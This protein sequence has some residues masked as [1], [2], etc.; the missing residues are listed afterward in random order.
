MEK[1]ATPYTRYNCRKYN[2]EYKDLASYEL[3]KFTEIKISGRLNV[4]DGII[5]TLFYL[6]KPEYQQDVLKILMEPFINYKYPTF[7]FN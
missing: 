2:L 7:N 1:C 6:I 3:G 5:V 4:V